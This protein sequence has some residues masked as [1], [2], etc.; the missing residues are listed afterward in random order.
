MSAPTSADGRELG[1]KSSIA[2]VI[3]SD[4]MTICLD[5]TILS[6]MEMIHG[7]QLDTGNG[8]TAVSGMDLPILNA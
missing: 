3:E 2:S 7:F 8:Q 4:I 5:P 1:D 6:N